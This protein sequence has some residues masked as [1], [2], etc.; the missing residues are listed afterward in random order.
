M[1]KVCENLRAAQTT[2]DQFVSLLNYYYYC[3]FHQ[4]IGPY[5]TE[6]D[7]PIT[8]NKP[9]RNKRMLLMFSWS[10]DKN[11]TKLREK[12]TRD[13]CANKY[14][15]I[16]TKTHARAIFYQV[17]REQSDASIFRTCVG[18]C[19]LFFYSL[20]LS[21]LTRTQIDWCFGSLQNDCLQ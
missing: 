8:W 12:K 19:H 15:H 21:C 6:T 9:Y 16:H 1:P 5:R 11:K 4:P 2:K 13:F 17:L 20:S 3:T 14:T 10:H 7:G 18:T